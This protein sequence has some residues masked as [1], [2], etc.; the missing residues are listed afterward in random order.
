[1]RF[2]FPLHVYGLEMRIGIPC[3]RKR[4]SFPVFAAS[5]SQTPKNQHQIQLITPSWGDEIDYAAALASIRACLISPA[6]PYGL[7]GPWAVKISDSFH[8]PSSSAGFIIP[9]ETIP[10]LVR[11]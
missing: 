3:D 8:S 9:P 1:M 10:L 6:E 7:Q 2:S 5:F 4:S 11:Y